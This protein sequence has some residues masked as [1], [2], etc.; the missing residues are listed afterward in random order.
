[1]LSQFFVIP[2]FLSSQAKTW[3]PR[4]GDFAQAQRSLG[5]G[6]VQQYGAMQVKA[7]S[8]VGAQQR[9]LVEPAKRAC[10]VARKSGGGR[11]EKRR[12]L[13][14]NTDGIHPAW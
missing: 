4:Q 6:Q 1:M 5:G 2:G 3:G 12:T 9:G 13:L 11:L 10:A 7:N 8:Q 14:T